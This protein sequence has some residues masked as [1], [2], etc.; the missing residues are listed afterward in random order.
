M[1]RL[2]R[3]FRKEMAS[4]A[5]PHLKCIDESGLNLGMTRR[6]GRAAP[7]Q[8]VREATPDY[9]GTPYTMIAAL[10][11]TGIS[12]PWLFEG[13]LN[14]PAFVTYVCAELAPT[15]QPGDIVILDHLSVHANAEARAAIEARGARVQFLSPYSSD[16]NPIEWVWAKVKAA[17]RQA[18]A[19]TFEALVEALAHALR[20][21]S[22]QDARAFFIHCGY[23]VE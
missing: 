4:L 20:S 18:K 9:S 21:I 23:T 15:L 12:A 19:R 3:A 17:L 11:L 22:E 13:A 16:F 7:D 6:Y 5:A 14:G 10:G 2:R 1:K 8:R